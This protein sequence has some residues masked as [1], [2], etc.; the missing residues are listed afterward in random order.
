MKLVGGSLALRSEIHVFL[1][2]DE[3]R[4]QITTVG[5]LYLVDDVVGERRREEKREPCHLIGLDQAS[6]RC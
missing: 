4:Q 6:P 3:S 2:L 1:L 5:D